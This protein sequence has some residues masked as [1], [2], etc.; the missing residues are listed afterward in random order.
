MCSSFSNSHTLEM[1]DPSSITIWEFVPPN[2]NDDIPQRKTWFSWM[3][4]SANE[5]FSL[6]KGKITPA[7]P[8]APSKCPI[9]DLTAPITSLDFIK[10]DKS[11]V[12][13]ALSNTFNIDFASIGSPK[14]VPVPWDSM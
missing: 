1:L 7:K 9:L 3:P 5:L 11:D 2:P 10:C 14:G 13:S 8:A 12:D 6:T 4:T